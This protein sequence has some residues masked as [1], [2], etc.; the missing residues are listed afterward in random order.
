L[1]TETKQTYG[2]K[3]LLEVIGSNLLYFGIGLIAIAAFLI[4]TSGLMLL[5]PGGALKVICMVGLGILCFIGFQWLA[6]EFTTGGTRA[7]V[8][9][10]T[11]NLFDSIADLGKNTEFDLFGDYRRNKWLKAQKAKKESGYYKDVNG[12]KYY[13]AA[14]DK[15]YYQLPDGRWQEYDTWDAPIVDPFDKPSWRSITSIDEIT[16][17]WK[18]SNNINFPEVINIS[19][20]F[21]AMFTMALRRNN[22]LFDVEFKL[23]L[24]NFLDSVIA[25]Y[26]EYF[27]SKD[28]LWTKFTENGKK[29]SNNTNYGNYYI[30]S[31][32]QNTSLENIL[33]VCNLQINNNGTK[34][35]VV[36]IKDIFGI[37]GA[38]TLTCILD[39]Q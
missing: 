27:E 15:F 8:E 28:V 12:L 30:S 24:E 20:P 33:N 6:P 36:M 26:P 39:K 35:N 17:Y 29:Q 32:V 21:T 19:P 14:Q 2:G 22:N 25:K 9:S 31:F 10:D 11:K 7:E 1:E 13:N 38:D 3:N 34:I 16:G 37:D 4:G 18:G 23:D 5:V